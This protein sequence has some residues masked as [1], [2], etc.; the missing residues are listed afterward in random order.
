MN[1]GH[2]QSTASALK[3]QIISTSRHITQGATELKSVQWNEGVKT[4]NFTA[5][6][7]EG[8]EYIVTLN[9]PCGYK[10]SDTCGMNISEENDNILRL[11]DD[12]DELSRT[13]VIFAKNRNGN[14]GSVNMRYVGHLMKFEDEHLYEAAQV[15]AP[16]S[17]PAVEQPY[18]PFDQQNEFIQ[19]DFQM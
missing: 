12:P 6:V 14:V 19:N 4:L 15:Q 9:I 13:E 17:A 2:S 10:V 3:P 8:D 7:V 5:E 11:S 1:P 18:N 16:T